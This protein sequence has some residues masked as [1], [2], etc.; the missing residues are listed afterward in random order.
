MNWNALVYNSHGWQVVDGNL[1]QSTN[2]PS[3]FTHA[4]IFLRVTTQRAC[5]KTFN[6]HPLILASRRRNEQEKII[7]TRLA[8]ITK[9][10]FPP[11]PLPSLV[12]HMLW[13]MFGSGELL[14]TVMEKTKQQ[15]KDLGNW[16]TAWCLNLCSRSLERSSGTR[17]E[18][19]YLELQRMW[20]SWMAFSVGMKCF[21][22]LLYELTGVDW[23]VT[24]SAPGAPFL[25]NSK[26]TH[27]IH[28]LSGWKAC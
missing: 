1:F 10:S 22:G 11:P 9:V 3:P 27:T 15:Q 25:V 26:I 24:R 21:N 20:N 28:N 18:T 5:M 13:S 8:A 16:N 7:A 19:L 4:H 12:R 17:N 6:V 2:P 23:V 14:A